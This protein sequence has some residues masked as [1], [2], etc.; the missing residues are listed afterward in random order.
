[1]PL[2]NGPVKVPS[3]MLNDVEFVTSTSKCPPEN[4]TGEIKEMFWLVPVHQR[5]LPSIDVFVAI[6]EA[7]VSIGALS[8]E[9]HVKFCTASTS[10]PD[11]CRRSVTVR[12]G[13]VTVPAKLGF[14]RG[15]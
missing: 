4:A 14:A 13:V 15:A 10:D 2:P 12:A 8:P 5:S 6:E 1:M 3:L 7:A 9:V 11:A